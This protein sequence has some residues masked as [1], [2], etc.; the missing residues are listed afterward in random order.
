MVTFTPV[1]SVGSDLL[2]ETIVAAISCPG[3]RGKVTNGFLPRKEFRSLPQRPTIR[4]FNNNWSWLSAGWGMASI[5]A[6]PGF[7]ITSAFNG[8]LEELEFD[9]NP[10]YCT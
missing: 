3:M 7:L 1:L 5:V 8:T 6:S 9:A 10:T 2:P 4:T